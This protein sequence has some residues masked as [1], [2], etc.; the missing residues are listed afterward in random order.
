MDLKVK[1]FAL[2]CVEQAQQLLRIHGVNAPT[3]EVMRLLALVD[4]ASARNAVPPPGI[5]LR[6]PE[7]A[8]PMKSLKE[9]KRWIEE[10]PWPKE[11]V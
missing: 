2:E 5:L 9:F 7:N 8:P 4:Y 1:K 10:L 6:H 11:S 3:G